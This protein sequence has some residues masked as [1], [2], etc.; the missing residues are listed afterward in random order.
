M[1]GDKPFKILKRVS[2]HTSMN[3]DG[4]KNL[5]TLGVETIIQ[6]YKDFKANYVYVDE[7]HGSMQ[8]EVLSKYFFNIGKPRTFKSVNFS[9][10]YQ[11]KDIYTGEQKTKRKK[12]MMVYFLQKRFELREI[13]ISSKEEPSSNS[14]LLIAQLKNYNVAR[15]D[16]KDDPVF[17]GLD[18]ILDA[19]LLAN[20]A[21][22]ENNESVFD[23]R[24]GNIVATI[25]RSYAKSYE[26]EHEEF[27]PKLYKQPS[28]ESHVEKFE[29]LDNRVTSISKKRRFSRR[30]DIDFDIF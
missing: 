2:L 16:S 26:T 22:I 3:K 5:Q 30:G 12:V 24:T 10:A 13:T 20:F 15:F 27:K 11:F 19:L 14:N 7:G 28:T 6:L 29:F 18:H 21:I 25:D 4:L 8:T 9:S 17:E 23:Q 1:L